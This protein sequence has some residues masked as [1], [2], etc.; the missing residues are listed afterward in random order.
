MTEAERFL[1]TARQ[2]VQ[3]EAK[4]LE[5]LAGA[6]DE[7]FAEAVQMML[8]AE[9]RVIVSGIGK[10]GHIGRKIAA[11]LASTGT[12]AHFV[13][14]SEASH[15]DLGMVARGDVVLA[16]SNSGEAPELA[17]LLSYTRRF[18]IPL[19]GLSSRMDSTLMQAADAHLLIPSLGEACG[20]G[21]VPTISTTLTLAMGDA[22][23]VAIMQHRDFGPEA[24]RNF[25]PGGKLGARLSTV[26][27]L[28]HTGDALPLVSEDTAM[29]DVL[30]EMTRKEFGVAGVTDDRGLLTGIITDGDLRRHMDGLLT[31]KAADVMTRGP[32]TIGPGALAEEAVAQ[33]TGKITC[34]FV[35]PEGSRRAEGLIRLHD[36]LRAG[37]G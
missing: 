32:R 37:V 21:M 10:S 15:G 24:F 17:N 34:L 19:I 16:I 31:Q 6:F 1:A 35:V 13:H 2:V 7:R 26:G 3:D 33:M 22:L 28:M 8:E 30:I 18:Q 25:H 4:A 36:C 23:A 20:F 29:P 12:P 11:T 14:P 5:A 9:G 27:D